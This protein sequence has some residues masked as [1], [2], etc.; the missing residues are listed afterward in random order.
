MSDKTLAI[1]FLIGTLCVAVLAT[2]MY[3][4]LQGLP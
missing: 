1:A 2:V 3:P 4:T